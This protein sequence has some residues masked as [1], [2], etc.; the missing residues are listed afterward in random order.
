MPYPVIETA[1]YRADAARL[2]SEAG[3]RAVVE[4]V[5]TAPGTG[6][7]LAAGRAL[8]GLRVTAGVLHR[9]GVQMAV[10]VC[11]G[12]QRPVFLIALLNREEQ[13]RARGR[14][15]TGTPGL[16]R[17]GGEKVLAGIE[18]MQAIIQGTASADSFRI[19]VL[20]SLDVRAIRRR[21]GLSQGEFAARFGFTPR[22]LRRWET[23]VAFPDSSAR[24]LL[25]VI[26]M[27]PAVVDAARQDAEG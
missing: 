24:T 9:A 27:A 23:G 2:L 8:R 13:P 26:A 22:D 20:E 6:T 11:H 25:R 10:S 21:L 15:G 16:P 18:D 5:A 12:P 1:R 3:Q 7:L 14:D 17:T 19:H 4:A